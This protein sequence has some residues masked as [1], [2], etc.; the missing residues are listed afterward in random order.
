M[1]INRKLTVAECSQIIGLFKGSHKKSDISKILGFKVSTVKKTIQHYGDSEMPVSKKRIGWP[2]LLGE[3]EK[4]ILGEII[5]SNNRTP[6]SEIKESFYQSTGLNRHA[7]LKMSTLFEVSA[8]LI[9]NGDD[10]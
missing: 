8:L 9:S 3:D 4:N 7:S 5:N 6:A 10:H 2:K 1:G